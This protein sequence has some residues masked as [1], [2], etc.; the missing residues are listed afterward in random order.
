MVRTLEDR[1]RTAA[2][3]LG[4]PS[5][6]LDIQRLLALLARGD[7]RTQLPHLL[8]ELTADLSPRFLE[9]DSLL[10]TA[11]SAPTDDTEA[12]LQL[13]AETAAALA[14]YH[15]DHALLG[16]R[17]AMLALYR[18]TP[19]D[20]PTYADEALGVG[21]LLA[22][23]VAHLLRTQPERWAAWADPRLDFT[24]DYFAVR[25]LERSYLLRV[26]GAVRER[27]HQALLR[28]ALGISPDDLAFAETTYHLLSRKLYTHATPTLFNAGTRRPQLSSCFL[29]TLQTDSVK[30]IFESL[31]RCAEISELAGGV[32]LS[33]H[34]LPAAG[35][36]RPGGG[37]SGG[38]VPLLRVFNETARYV[39]QGGGKRK[40]AFAVYLEPWHADVFDFLN[41]KKNTGAQELRARDL[42]Y[43]L[44]V[45]DL[46]LE[47]VRDDG[48]W[49]LF[50][51][52]QVPELPETCGE[53]FRAHYLRY[54][55]AGAALQTLPARKLWHA[56]LEAQIETGGP[57]LL[58][59]D[60]CNAKSNQRHLGTLKGS[61]LCAEIVEYTAPDEVAVCNLAS[62]ALSAFVDGRAFDFEALHAVAQHLA[63]ALDR[64]IDRNLYPVPEAQRSNARHRPIGIGVQGLA[65]CFH[66]LK[67]G[68]ESPDAATLN[69]AI[70]ETLYHGALTASVARAQAL[71]AYP[72]YPGSPLA[73]GTLQCDLWGVTPSPRWDWPALRAE[74]AR[75]GARNSLLIA[76]MPTASTSQLL[77]N[78]ECFEPY[79]SNLYL[80]RV[81]SGE[82]VLLNRH[83]VHELEALGLWGKP[84]LRALMA[85]DGSVQHLDL[86]Q[87]LKD[88]YKTVWELKQR[89]LIDLAADR[90]PYVC[91]SQSL[92]VFL[93]QP[94]FSQ[95]TSLH[96]YTWQRGLKTGVYYLRTR[97]AAQAIK[98]TLDPNE[99]RQQQNL[100]VGQLVGVSCAV[101]DPN[102]ESCG[103]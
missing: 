103:A 92:N 71:G 3:R 87:T 15:P 65:D 68:F 100:P 36:P 62:V 90:A 97:P 16:G 11:T 12:L 14:V 29:L 28:V 73:E 17:L 93:E 86:P 84:M 20:W 2:A 69:T 46:L 70:F 55:A 75:H 52:E 34:T 67:I 7:V 66:R 54:E 63:H 6:A 82:F 31:T 21:T 79:T 51:P 89:T 5:P 10:A 35:Q 40:G 58:Y 30:A 74:L 39:D 59:K 60:A 50:S 48:P 77:G 18:R 8:Q 9:L 49:S 78:T 32:G 85:A 1:C 72:S 99:L 61:N 13:A 81:L 83:L 41:L 26:G 33:V 43:A 98:F 44:W 37:V 94:T 64:I 47:R 53:A 91:Q 57:Y 42:F 19:P 56:I 95:L 27:P 80:R 24:Y 101:D 45:P 76:L 23:E 25:T 96:F 4:T 38:L 88:R 102:C 22:P